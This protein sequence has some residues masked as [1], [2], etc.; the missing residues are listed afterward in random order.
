MSDKN[1]YDSTHAIFEGVLGLNSD[2]PRPSRVSLDVETTN[3][4]AGVPPGANTGGHRSA[5]VTVDDSN[6]IMLRME[7][8]IKELTQASIGMNKD[9]GSK[10]KIRTYLTELPKSDYCNVLTVYNWIDNKL[11]SVYHIRS[12]KWTRYSTNKKTMC[13]RVL[14]CGIKVPA[15]TTEE[16][17]WY[18]ILSMAVNNKYAFSKSNFFEKAKKQYQGNTLTF[19]VIFFLM[20]F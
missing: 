5:R 16:D 14:D 9:K 4:I 13:Q 6:I 18:T 20:M 11:W 7:A 19:N 8:R 12:P 17:Y 15:G 1:R 2:N 3:N 10:S